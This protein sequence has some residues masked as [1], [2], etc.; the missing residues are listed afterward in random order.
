[1]SGIIEL[2]AGFGV[3]EDHQGWHLVYS[4]GGDQAV[5]I[6]LDGVGDAKEAATAAAIYL[7]N[8]AEEIDDAARN[9]TVEY[10][11]SDDE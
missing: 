7:R 8:V 5:I 11:E 2:S 1:M 4:Q 10:E 9:M 3:Q 6:P